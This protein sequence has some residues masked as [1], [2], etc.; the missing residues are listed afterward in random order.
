MVPTEVISI[1]S[2]IIVPFTQ[3]KHGLTQK[4]NFNLSNS[5]NMDPFKLIV[6]NHWL[7]INN[8]FLMSELQYLTIPNRSTD[9]I[10]LFILDSEGQLF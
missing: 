3:R 5:N 9:F 1:S 2:L 4:R 10:L 8:S 7:W 6:I